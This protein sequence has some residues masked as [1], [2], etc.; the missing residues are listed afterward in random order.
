MAR[1]EEQTVMQLIRRMQFF[2]ARAGLLIATCSMGL[3]AQN[4]TADEGQV[5]LRVVDEQGQLLHCR[6]HVENDEGKPQLARGLPSWR[7]H[8]S[9]RGEASLELAFGSYT[10][11][12]ARGP[13]FTRHTGS[14]RVTE[15]NRTQTISVALKRIADMAAA[16]WYS[17]DLHVHRPVKDMKLLMQ[18]E[19]LH[20]APVITWW[21]KRNLCQTRKLPD[22]LLVNFDGCRSYHVMAG[23]DERGGGALMYFNL[24]QP[25]P[26]T[27][28]E[29]EYPSPMQFLTLA[30]QQQDVWIDIEK[31]FWWDVP[32]WVASGQID[33]IGLA[34]NHMCHDGMYEDEAWGKPRDERRLRAPLGN[35]FWTQEIYYRLLNCGLRIP[36]S[37]GSASGVLPNPVGYNRAYVYVGDDFSYANW[38][39]GLKAGRSFVTNGPLLVTKA[40][41]RLPG[42][43]FRG[44]QDEAIAI[45]IDVSLTTED[46][47]SEIEI[48]QNGRIAK[49]V[50]LQSLEKTSQHTKT[51]RL[52]TIRFEK[53]GWFLIRAI[54]DNPRTFRF[55]SSA[56]YYVEV[57]EDRHS[58]D[59][60][61]AQFFLDWVDERI[62]RVKDQLT[63]PTK[64]ADVL[65]HHHDARKFWAEKVAVANGD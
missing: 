42:H 22:D 7:D 43:V 8:F 36:P 39:N 17:G 51:G 9:C 24:K 19:D 16:G 32:V 25:L 37:A 23:E 5:V 28:S 45:D 63:D 1:F 31:P 30:R 62:E 38:W 47:V 34:N 40:N 52:G 57:G 29:R 56:P 41:G 61:S 15:T 58:V 48:I 2:S 10:F 46:N 59:H 50:S 12:V 54:T 14:F 35:G 20:V 55:A 11:L 64:L 33:S 53:S 26:I 27:D 3:T 44:D 21:N 4:S 65:K 49:R 18:A 6:I 13:E 60:E